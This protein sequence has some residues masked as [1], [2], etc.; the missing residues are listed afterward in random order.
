MRAPAAPVSVTAKKNQ[1]NKQKLYRTRS[2]VH[3][4]V[5]LALFGDEYA[6]LRRGFSPC[7]SVRWSAGRRDDAF[8]S[9]CTDF[10]IEC[11]P[12]LH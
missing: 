9:E 5:C 1:T 7:P 4:C 3:A 8:N 12:S 6:G 10:S 2:K 11:D